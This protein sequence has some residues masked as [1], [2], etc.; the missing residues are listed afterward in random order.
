[1]T[2]HIDLNMN[3]MIRARRSVKDTAASTAS[4]L[5]AEMFAIFVTGTL[6]GR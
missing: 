6:R 4:L 5:K 3:A 1:M 2:P